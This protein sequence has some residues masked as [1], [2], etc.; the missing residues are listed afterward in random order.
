M[1]LRS[2]LWGDP[3]SSRMIHVDGDAS[4]RM[5]L[6]ELE[7]VATQGPAA[8]SAGSTPFPRCSSPPSRQ[9]L[10]R[11]PDLRPASRTQR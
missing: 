10:V 11:R 3:R 2:H 4:V 9:S 5:D 8:G 6:G 7:T 1:D